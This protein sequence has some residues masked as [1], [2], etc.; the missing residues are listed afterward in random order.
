MSEASNSAPEYSG[1]VIETRETPA[2]VQ[3]DTNRIRGKLH[4]RENERIKDALNTSDTFIAI[5]EAKV[6]DVEGL[7]LLYETGF[8]A[9][10]RQKVVW[11]IEDGCSIGA[12]QPG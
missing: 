3:T 5:T 7:A 1:P 10:N 8:L 12:S 6:F 2:I 4:L 9:L 11:V